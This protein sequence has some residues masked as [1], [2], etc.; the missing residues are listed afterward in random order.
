M[1]RAVYSYSEENIRNHSIV[2]SFCYCLLAVIYILAILKNLGQ[3]AAL[4]TEEEILMAFLAC[5]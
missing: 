4:S 2:I 1:C 3:D 5:E